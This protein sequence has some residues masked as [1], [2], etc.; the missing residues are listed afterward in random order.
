MSNRPST[1]ALVALGLVTA[2]ALA[3]Q[4][5]L[6]R[7]F[8]SVLAY[9]FSFLAISLSLLGT[10]AGALVVYIWP[11]RFDGDPTAVLGRWSVWFALSL[12]LLPLILVRLDLIMTGS[13]TTSFVIN[14]AV[15]CAVSAIPPFASGVVVA[16]AISKF[17][18]A[19]GVVYAAD[20]IGAGLGALAAVPL[21]WLGP[22]PNLVVL[23]GIFS[24]AAAYLFDTDATLRRRATAIGIAC[25]L[26]LTGAAF[27]RV[28]YLEPGHSK[29]QGE[30]VG[31]HWTPLTRAFGYDSVKK[32]AAKGTTF[33]LLLY[34][35][36]YAP[37]PRVE[38][39]NL[40]N[41]KDLRTGP[42]SIGYELT[43]PGHALVI[44][45]GGGRDIYT[46]LSQGQTVDVIE[47]NEGI[48]RVV[49][50]DLGHVSGAP[51]SR[52]GVSTVIGDGRSALAARD[53][54]YD[55]IHIGFTDTL[56]AN[57][58]QGFALAENNL[59]TIEAFQ[60][61]FDHLKPRGIL[62]VSRLYQ[63]VG[64]E[65]L[66]VAVLAQAALEVR[67]L[68][69]PRS[70]MLVIRGT[71]FLG[72]PTGT[73]LLR[74]D[75]FSPAE[76]AF[77]ER[78]AK[79]RGDGVVYGPRG[80]YEAE[81]K[82]LAEAPSIEAFCNS[83]HLDVCP[84]T[85]D[86]P[87]FFNMERL[88]AVGL[89]SGYYG[90][91]ASPF[92][93]LLLTLGILIVL[94][95]IAFVTPLW[96]APD[97]SPPPLGALSY[98]L[99]IGLGF[100]LVEITLIQRLVLFLGFPTY[101]LSV[102]LFSLLIFSGLGSWMTTFFEP[103][104]GMQLA[105]AAAIGLILV[106]AYALQPVLRSL[107]WLPLAGRVVVAVL[108]VAPIAT[109]LGMAMPLGLSRLEA[110]HPKALPYAWGINGIA[111]VLASVLG[112]VVAML[113]GFTVAGL[114]AALCYGA[115]LVHAF[116]GDWPETATAK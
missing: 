89:G 84:P 75:P 77:I 38:G 83:Y 36:A 64:D 109:S 74:M 111:S 106:S 87:F 35:R 100:L 21:L 65:A 57:A 50:E 72:P 45:G 11:R 51:Y 40:P 61:Y 28:I 97:K 73:V 69:D 116:V 12:L 81:W 52:K 113:Y 104:R 15:A 67:G 88:S 54:K 85:D 3:L 13:L 2:T 8:S 1:S 14:L 41:W 99:F 31:E 76:V 6:T 94:S 70:H 58:A 96:M 46:A 95:A 25:V 91:Q 47:L 90:S 49:D 62:N 102:V 34:D 86:K 42:Q 56:S 53:T 103:R 4:V 9:H 39:D 112:V 44:G 66:R 80:P 105:L 115:A 93:M 55:Q 60:D 30:P 7:I 63:L 59:Y 27:T 108:L 98:F 110:L 92:S 17:S 101:A 10:G 78:M 43:G 16:V 114:V 26:L 22:A 107:I 24:A 79:E 19:I 18:S 82:D 23:L 32:T 68:E 37:V 29:R 71:D 20:L 33:A 5:V 48:R